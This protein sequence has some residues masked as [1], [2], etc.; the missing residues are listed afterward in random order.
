MSLRDYLHGGQF[1]KKEVF[2]YEPA[3]VFRIGDSYLLKG[4]GKGE[5]LTITTD[6]NR[7]IVQ[8]GLSVPVERVQQF[9]VRFANGRVITACPAP[10]GAQ[11]QSNTEHRGQQGSGAPEYL[12]LAGN[13]GVWR[14]R[15]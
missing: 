14:R 10:R 12:R 15:G 6:D 3:E 4:M 1:V 13:K 2:S 5:I 11:R 8:L 9:T 7:T